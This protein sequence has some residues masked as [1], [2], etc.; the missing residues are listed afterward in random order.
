M[1]VTPTN[2]SFVQ[3]GRAGHWRAQETVNLPLLLWWFDS[4]PAHQDE[5]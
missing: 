5:S 2:R 4:T 3:L 1:T